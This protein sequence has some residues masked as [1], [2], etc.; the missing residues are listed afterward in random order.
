MLI[1]LVYAVHV[2]AGGW[3]DLREVFQ[4]H[5]CREVWG[6]SASHGAYWLAYNIYDS[7][8][9]S[10]SNPGYRGSYA[11]GEKLYV[12]GKATSSQNQGLYV[13]DTSTHE[14][15]QVDGI[16]AIN[17]WFTTQSIV[18]GDILI[19]EP[20]PAHGYGGHSQNDLRIHSQ[21][22]NTPWPVPNCAGSIL[23]THTGDNFWPNVGANPT[24]HVGIS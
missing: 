12:S 10:G 21:S 14:G 18:M 11:I 4:R 1:A 22:N 6:Y 23:A 9:G 8:H 15:W 17:G 20:T 13:Y 2:V 3:W 16:S 19:L 24:V 5:V 7:S